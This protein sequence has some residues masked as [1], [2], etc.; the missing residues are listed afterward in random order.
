MNSIFFSLKLPNRKWLDTSHFEVI[1]NSMYP[2]LCDESLQIHEAY[3]AVA[4]RVR[5][6]AFFFGAQE[7][8]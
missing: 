5:A 2:F 8:P 1:T 3:D 7:E 4:L 6:F